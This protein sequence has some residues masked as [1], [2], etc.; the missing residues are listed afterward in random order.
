[1]KNVTKNNFILLIPDDN[2][3][4]GINGFHDKTTFFIHLILQQ[5]L[6]RPIYLFTR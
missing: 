5:R 3:K 2:R 4:S 1:M 6:I